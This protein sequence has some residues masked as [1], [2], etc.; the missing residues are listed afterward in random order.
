MPID[1]K[2][3]WL[4]GILALILYSI[5]NHETTYKVGLQSIKEKKSIRQ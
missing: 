5:K 1:K 3:Y 2:K 4:Q